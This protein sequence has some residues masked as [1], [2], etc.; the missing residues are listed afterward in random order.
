MFTL[1]SPLVC[2]GQ[3]HCGLWLTVVHSALTPHEAGES[4]GLRQRLSI[5]LADGGQ[6]TSVPQSPGLRH[7]VWTGSPTRPSGHEHWKLPGTLRQLCIINDLLIYNI[8]T[9]SPKNQHAVTIPSLFSA[10][11]TSFSFNKNDS[12]TFFYTLKIYYLTR[13]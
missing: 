3:R 8:K 9:S 6:S 7:P 10:Q 13:Q 11:I 12:E 1:A 5:Q 4:H 2:G